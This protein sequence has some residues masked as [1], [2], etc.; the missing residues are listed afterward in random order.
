M[1]MDN[2]AAPITISAVWER[3]IPTAT[4]DIAK[5]KLRAI[6][7]AMKAFLTFSL[8]LDCLK[9]V[10]EHWSFCIKKCLE[11]ND[12]FVATINPFN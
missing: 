8:G 10:L 2:T 3:A 6:P 11:N 7:V 5:I 4:S 12:G 1:Q 9:E